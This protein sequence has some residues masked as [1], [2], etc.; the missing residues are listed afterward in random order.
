MSIIVPSNHTRIETWV[1]SKISGR[2]I[3]L[4]LIVYLTNPLIN[5][6][7]RI[8]HKHRRHVKLGLQ[9]SLLQ[10][11]RHVKLGLQLSLLHYI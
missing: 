11:R 6:H 10:H 7:A 9:L 3:L 8:S 1:N 5:R 4:E 2:N